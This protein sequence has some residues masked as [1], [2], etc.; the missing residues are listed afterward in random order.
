MHLF[1]F[2]YIDA[3]VEEPN[4]FIFLKPDIK[5]RTIVK[6]NVPVIEQKKC[7]LCFKCVD[8]C[9]FNVFAKTKN[10]VLIFE[11]LCH[12]CG[13]C[14][15][16]CPYG[17]IKYKKK[18][19][20][21]IETGFYNNLICK[22]GILNIGEIIAIPIIKKLL[23][24]L[25]DKINII[26]SSPGTSCNAISTLSFADYVVLVAEPTKFGLHDLKRIVGVVKEMEKP[27]GVIINKDINEDIIEKYCYKNKIELLGKIKYDKK[28]AKLYS[29]GK[30]LG[31]DYQKIFKKI[32]NNIKE[33]L[34]K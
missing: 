20:G 29:E 25:N 27:F 11:K 13:G 12:S 22:Q 33:K 6:V 26:D 8:F 14:K 16:V 1:N 17:A 3:D 31:K 2:N 9:E 15:M 7:Q 28:I 19:I 24:N 10:K 5:E 21:V 30:L 34:C 23:N 18:E 32:G 4:G